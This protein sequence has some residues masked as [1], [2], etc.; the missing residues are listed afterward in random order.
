[1]EKD[2]ATRHFLDD[3]INQSP[4]AHLQSLQPTYEERQNYLDSDNPE[5]KH[6]HQQSRAQQLEMLTKLRAY[7]QKR[8]ASTS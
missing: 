4:P 5:A 2:A 3:Y 8:Q 6:Y 1:M 7:K